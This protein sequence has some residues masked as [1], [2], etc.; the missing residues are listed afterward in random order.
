MKARWL[1]K[2]KQKT[3]DIEVDQELGEKVPPRSKL[4]QISKI[5]DPESSAWI[6]AFSEFADT[7]C[8]KNSR[9]VDLKALSTIETF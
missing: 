2:W 6:K 8:F 7:S 1:A 9:R 3:V 4:F 5:A